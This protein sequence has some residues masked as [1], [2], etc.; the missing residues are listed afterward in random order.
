MTAR[1]AVVAVDF[2]TA[3]AVVA[4]GAPTAVVEVVSPAAGYRAES[5]RIL[6]GE[7]ES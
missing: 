1:L 5:L 6:F 2:L 4:A 7:N 3:G